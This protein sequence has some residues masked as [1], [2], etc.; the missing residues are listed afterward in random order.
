MH[1]CRVIQ[2]A[3]LFHKTRRL[4]FPS[5]LL[6]LSL[7]KRRVLLSKMTRL[8]VPYFLLCS[9]LR[10]YL[11]KKKIGQPGH[12]MEDK[13]AK[14]LGTKHIMMKQQVTSFRL[15]RRLQTKDLVTMVSMK[16]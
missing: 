12:W 3:V 11:K 7:L 6:T 13:I 5:G 15:I 1:S 16:V 14:E 8:I 4:H 2:R 10:T 9:R